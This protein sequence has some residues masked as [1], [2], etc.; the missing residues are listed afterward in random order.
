[1]ANQ[2]S[3]LPERWP[4]GIGLA[5][6]GMALMVMYLGEGVAAMEGQHWVMLFI[7]L[8]VGY[9]LG[10]LWTQPAQMLGLP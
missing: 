2:L 10:R 1:L 5:A 8:V 6:G 4:W 9:V 7:V 3:S